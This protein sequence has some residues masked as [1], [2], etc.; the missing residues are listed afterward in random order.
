MK[1]TLSPIGTARSPTLS[2]GQSPFASPLTMPTGTTAQDLLNNVMGLPRTSGSDLHRSR[3]SESS[4]PQ[5]QLLFGSGP[6][7]QPDHSIWSTSLDDQSLK[8]VSTG[9]HGGYHSPQQ[10]FSSAA[11]QEPSHTLWSSPY[12]TTGQNTQSHLTTAAQRTTSLSLPQTMAN[13]SMHKRTP[14][15][16][17]SVAQLFANQNG[18]SN[19]PFVYAPT[20]A[21]QA[22]PSLGDQ[23]AIG[24]YS[25]SIE[26]EHGAGLRY[27]YSALQDYRSTHTHQ[28][29][30]SHSYAGPP[31]SSVWGNS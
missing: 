16:S 31:V 9:T 7:N 25:R 27:G 21:Q 24:A 23:V 12:P 10:H 11:S 30:A 1:P 15:A 26:G 4:A 29:R 2:K 17:T 8:F 14:S 3:H 13:P 22:L 28:H 6:P 5:P 20:A 19:D 18:S